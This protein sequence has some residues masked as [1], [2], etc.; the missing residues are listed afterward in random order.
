MIL[1]RP[2]TGPRYVW[3]GG[4]ACSFKHATE[5]VAQETCLREHAE[6]TKQL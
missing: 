6:D 5:Q 1:I 2:F 3:V 4:T